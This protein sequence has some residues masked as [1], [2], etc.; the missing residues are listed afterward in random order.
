MH[1]YSYSKVMYFNI[2]LCRNRLYWNGKRLRHTKTI[3]IY[4][5]GKFCKTTLNHWKI[6]Q[7][8]STYL[9]RR[10]GSGEDGSNCAASAEVKQLVLWTPATLWASVGDWPWKLRMAEPRFALRIWV[11]WRIGIQNKK[12]ECFHQD[13]ILRSKSIDYEWSKKTSCFQ[14]RD[15]AQF[16]QM[17]VQLQIF[18]GRNETLRFSKFATDNLHLGCFT[19]L[20]ADGRH[21]VLVTLKI[22]FL[23][24]SKCGNQHFP[25]L[26]QGWR[27]KCPSVWF[28]VLYVLQFS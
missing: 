16:S 21:V 4:I 14:L 11:N 5:C 18:Q 13:G 28:I 2:F 8:R 22:L 23:P 19:V 26:P 15:V 3:Y 17:D 25:A 1:T 12:V 7:W 10:P 6:N 24:D 9:D 20:F 27:N